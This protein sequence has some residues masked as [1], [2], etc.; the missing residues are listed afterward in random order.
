MLCKVFEFK[1]EG[2]VCAAEGVVPVKG[3]EPVAA[4]LPVVGIVSVTGERTL[5]RVPMVVTVSFGLNI[6]YRAMRRSP[7]RRAR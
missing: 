7:P 2:D 6:T 1:I 3:A 5:F 4:G